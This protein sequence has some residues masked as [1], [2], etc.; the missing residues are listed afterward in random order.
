MIGIFGTFLV[1]DRCRRLAHDLL[2]GA[3][4]PE[5]VLDLV[6]QR[7]SDTEVT[8]VSAEVD[9]D[10]ADLIEPAVLDLLESMLARFAAAEL[11]DDLTPERTRP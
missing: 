10:R 6:L 1:P 7:D 4:T 9:P 11:L 3:P 5:G 2:D 8:V